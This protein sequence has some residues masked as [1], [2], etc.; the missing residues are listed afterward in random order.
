VG[1]RRTGKVLCLCPDLEGAEGGEAFVA[2]LAALLGNA[3][4]RFNTHTPGP[5]LKGVVH[6]D[7][8]C[9]EAC[10]QKW[11]A[12]MR[13]AVAEAGPQS[14]GS[15]KPLAL[16]VNF[17]A[18]SATPPGQA[19]AGHK[20]AAGRVVPIRW[21]GVGGGFLWRGSLKGGQGKGKKV[22]CCMSTRAQPSIISPI[23]ISPV[24]PCLLLSLTPPPACPRPA[25]PSPRVPQQAYASP[26][27]R[28]E[29]EASLARPDAVEAVVY[30]RTQVPAATLALTAGPPPDT[31]WQRELDAAARP[32]APAAGRRRALQ[33]AVRPPAPAGGGG[34]E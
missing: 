7:P 27:A 10:E 1:G 31:P 6:F 12:E 15:R 33:Q 20:Q 34:R 17:L 29:F 3:L 16:A 24:P 14:P 22:Y 2:L 5:D 30:L 28:A 4:C 25:L 23:I 32:P 11:L 21:G 13:A 9:F 26:A 18:T 19:F 8:G